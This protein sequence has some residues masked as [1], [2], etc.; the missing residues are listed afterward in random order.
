MGLNERESKNEQANN[1]ITLSVPGHV[2]IRC[3]GVC[4]RARGANKEG[5]QGLA[6]C[7]RDDRSYLATKLTDEDAERAG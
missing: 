3:S 5:G 1:V 4:T 2:E 7:A 6:L